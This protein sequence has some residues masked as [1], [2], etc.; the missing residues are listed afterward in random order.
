MTAA[1]S[2]ACQRIPNLAVRHCGALGVEGARFPSTLVATGHFYRIRANPEDERSGVSPNTLHAWERRFGYP[3]PQRSAGIGST[4]TA[5][6]RRDGMH[7]LRRVEEACFHRSASST[8]FGAVGVRRRWADGWLPLAR[9]PSRV[10]VMRHVTRAQARLDPEGLGL[11]ALERI[12]AG[13]RRHR[14]CPSAPDRSRRRR[15]SAEPPKPS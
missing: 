5:R 6:S 15:R 9:P 14:A 3:K 13:A 1:P 7:A 10:R 2:S 4:P 8:R 12:C 11:H